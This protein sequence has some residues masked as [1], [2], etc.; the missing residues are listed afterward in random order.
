MSRAALVAA[1]LL[2]GL[3]WAASGIALALLAVAI[4]ALTLKG[5]VIALLRPVA[6][7]AANI[8]AGA[9][10]LPHNHRRRL[11]DFGRDRQEERSTMRVWTVHRGR[12]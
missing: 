3:A 10:I 11:P 8:V 2:P 1:L 4:W 7:D 6:R 9:I 5:G 12:P